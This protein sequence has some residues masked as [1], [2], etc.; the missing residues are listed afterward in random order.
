MSGEVRLT[1]KAGRSLA[2]WLDREEPIGTSYIQRQYGMVYDDAQAI[3]DELHLAE[4]IEP[5][6]NNSLRF[7]ITP[8]GRAWLERNKE[9]QD[10][11]T[12]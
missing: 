10:V 7:T 11:R 2:F 6:W 12:K 1:V 8:A 4:L 5:V 3:I 9:K